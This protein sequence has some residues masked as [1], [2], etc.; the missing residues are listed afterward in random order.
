MKKKLLCLSTTYLLISPALAATQLVAQTT[1]TP[2]PAHQAIAEPVTPLNRI[3]AIVND[4]II[5]QT[6][7]ESAIAEFKQQLLAANAPIPPAKQLRDDVLQ[8]LI[9]YRLEMQMAIR[10][11]IKPTD[12]EVDQAI[13]QIAKN[14]N[15]TLEQ[16]QQQLVLQNLNYAQFRK[17]IVEQLTIGKLQQQMVAGQVKVTEADIAAFKNSGQG[18]E[19][20][21][22]IDFFLPISEHPTDAELDSTLTAAHQIQQQL[23]NG[24]DIDKITPTYQDLGWRSA[25]DLPQIFIQQ[26][27]TLTLKN[28]SQPIRAPNG[29]HVLKILEKRNKNQTLTDAQIREILLQQKYAAAVK[30]AI[31]KARAQ[32]YVAIIPQ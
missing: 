30:T 23:N 11:E 8:Q 13:D 24:V 32:A 7:L 10:Y 17:K 21:R 19:E 29:Y 1:A 28:A 22:L 12:A 25:G 20:Y 9:N 26:L 27:P 15:M 4:E 2:T 31:N 3:A 18:Q 6:E 14:H 16:L 5:S